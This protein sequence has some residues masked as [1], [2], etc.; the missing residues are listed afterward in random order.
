MFHLKRGLLRNTKNILNVYV[1]RL[2]SSTS[3]S[4]STLK[5]SIPSNGSGLGK[6]SILFVSG[7]LAGGSLVYYQLKNN[8]SETTFPNSSTTKLKDCDELKY[9]D[10]KEAIFELKKQLG[11][12]KVTNTKFEIEHHS[13][14]SWATDHARPDEYPLAI[15]YPESTEEVSKALKICH[16][17]KVPV[18]PFTGGTSLE[19]HFIST[20]TGICIDLSKMNKIIELHKE[21]LDIVVQPAVGWESLRDYLN[22]Y[23][24]LFGPDPGPGA[25]IG[26]MVATSCSGTNAARYGTMRENVVSVT[27]VLP[28]GTIV[29]TKRRPR[30]SSAGYN[31]TNLFI[32]S[33]GTLGIVTEVTLKLNI[34][35][36]FE[37]VALIPFNNLAGAA[38]SVADIIQEGIQ[39]NAIELL[40]DK[41]MHFVNHS[42]QTEVKYEELPT[43]LLK[44]GG[45][46]PEATGTLTKSV[47]DIVKK[48]GSTGFKFASSEEEKF[49]L[50]NARKVALWSTIQYGK[51]TIDKDIQ[52][53]STDV[54]VPISKFVESLE[55]TKEEIEKSGLVSSI[56]GHAGDGNYHAI[57]L[58]KESERKIASQLV[59][60][61]VQ[62]ALKLDGTV[63]GE[64]G[65]GVG[66]KEFLIDEVGQDAVDLMRKIKFAIDP[67]KILNPDKV[68]AIDPVNDRT[69]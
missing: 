31:L 69:I 45:T 16:D 6:Q 62:R 24:L 27:V 50:W 21:D 22:D 49:E 3:T 12:S 68:F 59:E 10:A 23:N 15:V 46:S 61:M 58:F 66:K 64:H 48:N 18:V 51:D 17:L 5:T 33:E 28:D 40:D 4:S 44:I 54:A 20:R 13:D 41:M 55:A 2:N 42:N 34:K 8:P 52:V 29:K 32:G 26:G 7:I 11:E 30:K 36:K 65:I 63:S 43:L 67:H 38:K 53:W 37:N 9:G 60:N 57:I 35:P 25:C 14:S 56:V 1:K 39:L 19:G 47:Q